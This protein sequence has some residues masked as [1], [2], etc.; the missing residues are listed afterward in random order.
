MCIKNILCNNKYS[1]V[2]VFLKYKEIIENNNLI[3]DAHLF[4]NVPNIIDSIDKNL[5]PE[6]VHMCTKALLYLKY[7]ETSNTGI[8]VE[9]VCIYL[10]YWIYHY[11]KNNGDSKHAK[12]F[13]KKILNLF[14]SA[15]FFSCTNYPDIIK[16]SELEKL[17]FLHDMYNILNDI[18]I[19][20][21]SCKESR[22]KCAYDCALMYMQKIDECE[23]NYDHDFCS[24]LNNI[25]NEINA[26]ELIESCDN[27]KNLM[28]P[29]FDRENRILDPVPKFSTFRFSMYGLYLKQRIKGVKEK[30]INFDEERNTLQLFDTPK[31]ISS[32]RTYNILYNR[33]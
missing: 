29:N 9:P 21:P 27:V 8:S 16:T 25:K 31:G 11:L 22:C 33:D 7:I 17:K 3:L 26:Q 10:Y 23:L 20:S 30:Y 24:E 5:R 2:K 19:Q 4:S 1:V 32:D 13:Y 18:K 12:A 28:F 14:Q 6:Y 15:I